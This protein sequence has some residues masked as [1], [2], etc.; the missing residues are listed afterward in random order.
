MNR[1][2]KYKEDYYSI[3]LFHSLGNPTHVFRDV[4]YQNELALLPKNSLQAELLNQNDDS[5]FIDISRLQGEDHYSW[6]SSE[7]PHVIQTKK[8]EYSINL[9]TSFDG[10]IWIKNVT[11][12]EYVIK[13]KYHWKNKKYR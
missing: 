10:V 12:P 8:Y 6:I 4:Y 3:G 2:K 1:Y 7:I 13:S 9:S 11:S 5:G